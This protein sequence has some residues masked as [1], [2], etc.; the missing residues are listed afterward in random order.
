[1]ITGEPEPDL[2][3]FSVGKDMAVIHAAQVTADGKH[4]MEAID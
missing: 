2:R 3:V 1:M 4:V